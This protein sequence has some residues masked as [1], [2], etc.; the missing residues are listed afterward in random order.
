MTIK[1]E[2]LTMK[3]D[4]LLS[5]RIKN[6]TSNIISIIDSPSKPL[7]GSS[8][9]FRSCLLNSDIGV[10]SLV[11]AAE[12]LFYLVTKL[13][14]LTNSNNLETLQATFTHEIKAFESKAQV[15]GYQTPLIVA[16]RYA[17][18]SLID[19]AIRRTNSNLN[20]D[21]QNEGLL[22]IFH[23]QNASESHFFA[24]L[25]QA[26]ID[27]ATNI[28]LLELMYFCLCLG[29]QGNY[30]SKNQGHAELTTITNNLY[31][32]IC[33][34]HSAISKKLLVEEP[35]DDNSQ[36][37]IKLKRANPI[38]IALLISVIVIILIYFSLVIKLDLMIKPLTNLLIKHTNSSLLI[39]E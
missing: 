20:V 4:N 23:N 12:P 34:H 5:P 31:H 19:D 15:Y 25:E 18:C 28:D 37:A 36:G 39:G 33:Q 30:S 27:S 22:K 3:L 16:A 29:Y 2:V 13:D 32:S 11:A 35:D 7:T 9:Y 14:E 26:Y 38:I 1:T 10:N 17:L 6:D 8:C 21:W 24:I